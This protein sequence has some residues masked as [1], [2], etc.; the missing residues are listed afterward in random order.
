VNG[1]H[2]DIGRHGN[3]PDHNT[4]KNCVEK[5][6]TSVSATKG[7]PWGRSVKFVWTPENIEMGRAAIDHSTK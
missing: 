2:F 3:V 4:I 6:P 1:Q 5:C 7:T